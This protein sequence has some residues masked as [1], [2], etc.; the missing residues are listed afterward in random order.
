[1]WGNT[2]GWCLSLLMLCG[3]MFGMNLLNRLG[4]ISPPT[5]F[6][7]N[8]ANLAQV[9]LPISPDSL[10]PIDPQIDSTGTYRAAIDDC[11]ANRDSYERFERSRQAGDAE[12]LPG[13]KDLLDAAP[14]HA[15]IFSA[16]ASQV[17]TY[18]E[19]PS[20]DALKTLGHLCAHAALLKQSDNPAEAQK[21]F[22]AEFALGEKLYF[23]RLTVSEF[24]AGLEL[25]SES[26][27]GLT[28]LLE[29]SGEPDQAAKFHEFDQARMNY[30]NDRILPVLKVLQSIDAN[31]IADHAGDLFYI[32]R[33]SQERMYR[34]E[35]IFALGRMRYYAGA[36]G[37]IGN[38]SG[39]IQEL[40]RL[41]KNSDPII[42]LAA[43]QGRD[44]T[45]EQ[46]RAIR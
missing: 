14:G 3:L 45:I 20:L 37:R 18:G 28:R 36:D 19:T 29:K 13:L 40:K 41:T 2:Q 4:E 38:Q 8:P 1:M 34:V 12:K 43:S 9:S 27:G 5:S 6:G 11:T 42:Q 15:N 7:T 26:A 25:L 39:A 23:E 22:Q 24:V 21:Y 30:Y 17:V 10:L 44:L 31:I 33:N 16:N 46:Y 35:A 32:E